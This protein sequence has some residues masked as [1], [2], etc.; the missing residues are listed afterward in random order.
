MEE[1]GWPPGM[2]PLKLRLVQLLRRW[3][4]VGQYDP[5]C[6]RVFMVRSFLYR[7]KE[8]SL[9]LNW[10]R[11]ILEDWTRA[12]C[13]AHDDVHVLKSDSGLDKTS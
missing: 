9:Y 11:G 7:Q 10:G 12:N 1:F 5:C 4:I 13:P 8:K 6:E 2:R 3:R